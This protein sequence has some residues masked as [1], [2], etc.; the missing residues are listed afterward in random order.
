VGRAPLRRQPATA[1]RH[2]QPIATRTAASLA[3]ILAG[4]CLCCL[5][6]VVW[7]RV[8]VRCDGFLSFPAVC[9]RVARRH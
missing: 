3:P 9:W 1:A 5:L 7:L 8:V 4:L 6:L 2:R